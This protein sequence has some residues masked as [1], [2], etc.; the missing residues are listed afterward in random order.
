VD[1]DTRN[2]WQ[3]FLTSDIDPMVEAMMYS[4]LPPPT[5]DN[6]TIRLLT[7][8]PGSKLSPIQGNIWKTNLKDG[9]V[10]EALSYCWGDESTKTS[11]MVSG[12][13][14]RVT[15][16]L[17]SAL[18]HLRYP[19]KRRILW[20]DAICINQ[21]DNTEKARQV[22]KMTEIYQTAHQTIVWLGEEEEKSAKA[23]QMCRRILKE[24]GP[25]FWK[26]ALD[27]DLDGLREGEADV[28]ETI[29]SLM[30]RM[31]EL[32]A[33]IIPAGDSA[34][35]PFV[36]ENDSDDDEPMSLVQRRETIKHH[37]QN[38]TR[39]YGAVNMYSLIELLNDSRE[40]KPDEASSHTA[41]ASTALARKES[42]TQS[43]Q[44]EELA[45][46]Y[47]V[48]LRFPHVLALQAIFR[49]PW[50]RRVWIIQEVAISSKATV[51]C[52]EEQID[53][54]LLFYAVIVIAIQGRQRNQ[55]ML[56]PGV[57]T[58]IY[59]GIARNM[60]SKDLLDLKVEGLFSGGLLSALQMYRRFNAT[61]QRDKVSF[62][63]YQTYHFKG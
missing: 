44:A 46:K 31:D 60:F 42:V 18:H 16:N 57:S 15:Q 4:P 1:Q 29:E 9:P 21:E 63:S 61:N 43:D 25:A 32:N 55:L 6:L 50:F 22:S 59:I 45:R 13:K 19:D 20:I 27:L 35:E 14:L 38:L 33:V 52:G 24:R 10:F 48:T 17:K 37:L 12:V 39:I 30:E 53:W 62:F 34:F 8:W 41:E 26:Y 2:A 56:E 36:G 28:R 7:L 49:R 11:I 5:D 3:E 54:W 51:V 58:F 47:G 40:E 23:I